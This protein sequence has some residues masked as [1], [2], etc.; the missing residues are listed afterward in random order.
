LFTMSSR[1]EP[2]TALIEICQFTLG[3]TAPFVHCD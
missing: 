3:K 1:Q 2:M